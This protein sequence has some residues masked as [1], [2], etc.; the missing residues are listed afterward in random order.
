MANNGENLPDGGNNAVDQAPGNDDWERYYWEDIPG[1]ESF[2]GT[3]RTDHLDRVESLNTQIASLAGQMSLPTAS[4]RFRNA[5]RQNLLRLIRQRQSELD[6]HIREA[7]KAFPPPLCKAFAPGDRQ[8]EPRFKDLNVATFKPEDDRHSVIAWLNQVIAACNGWP[9]RVFLQAL[10]RFSSG[11]AQVMI[12]QWVDEGKHFREILPLIERAFG[13]LYTPEEAQRRLF[14]MNLGT[15]ESLDALASRVKAMV[16]LA[17]R[18]DVEPTKTANQKTLSLASFYQA[19][20]AKI[21]EQIAEVRQAT[22]RSSKEEWTFE[23]CLR[24]A[25]RIWEIQRHIYKDGSSSSKIHHSQEVD[26]VDEDQSRHSRTDN[27]NS[28][29]TVWNDYYSRGRS[30]S[31]RRSQS[32]GRYDR[33]DGSRG[34]RRDS[35]YR[36]RRRSTSRNRRVSRIEDQESDDEGQYMSAELVNFLL[37]EDHEDIREVK[38]PKGFKFR[39]NATELGVERDECLKCGEKGHFM[40]GRNARNCRYFKDSLTMKC[41]RCNKGGHNSSKCHRSSKN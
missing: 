30:S 41:T 17:T 5:M 25:N 9:E 14:D 13:N 6:A 39:V 10:V 3:F 40:K 18:L 4:E 1:L 28:A 38:T 33:R 37:G 19:L 21:K 8:N 24:E 27:Y 26:R 12:E 2:P 20:P 31:R 29:S 16:R 7:T 35:P 15:N 22:E 34:S 11:K 23:I 32:R 36:N